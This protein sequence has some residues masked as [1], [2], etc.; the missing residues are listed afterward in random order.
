MKISFL[1]PDLFSQGA[2]YVTALLVRGFV[3][4]GY[5]VDLLVTP[6][7]ADLLAEGKVPFA[8]PQKTNWII[9]P[10]R[11]ARQNIRSLR[12]YL[13]T[14]DTHAI[15][16]MA[17]HYLYALR[18]ASIGLKNIPK[19]MYVEHGP[20]D[21]DERGNLIQQLS[22][23][24][25]FSSQFYHQRCDF[26]GVVSQGVKMGYERLFPWAKGKV[27]VMYNPVVDDVFYKKIQQTEGVHPWLSKKECPTFV[28]AAA[29][30]PF[31]NHYL[32]FDS[33]QNCQKKQKMRLVLFG[34]GELTNDYEKYIH[35]HNL[36][37][38]VC[39]AG[40]TDNLPLQ[41]KH[42]DGFLVSSNEES[43]SVVLIEAMACGCPIVS[44]NC[45]YGPPELLGYGKY[46]TLVPIKDVDAMT[47]AILNLTD[48]KQ[49]PTIPENVWKRFS[50]ESIVERYEQVLGLKN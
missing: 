39:L 19:I 9:L 32:L 45:A 35:E 20:A 28:A 8:V 29:H 5:Q 40:Y 25:R 24:E 27:H 30:S 11:H 33:I 22:L 2:E 6:R 50:L 12:R 36:E 31:K 46:G 47:K 49:R 26:V 16:V 14:T 34:R 7:H 48:L 15:V 38:V 18:F 1:I 44:T 4:K 3:A 10:K 42:A 37:E 13:K 23:R 43:F 21:V 41:L 17:R